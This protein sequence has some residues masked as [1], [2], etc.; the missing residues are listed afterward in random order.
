[1][2]VQS[3]ANWFI[4]DATLMAGCAM[5]IFHIFIVSI[6][7]GITE[8]LPISSSAHLILLPHIAGV[9]DQGMM[10]DVSVHLGTLIAVIVFFWADAKL[11]LLGL[12]GLLRG[13][14]EGRQSHLAIALVI[15]TIPA[16]VVGLVLKLTGVSDAMRDSVGL[17]GA[18]MLGFGIVLWWI[19]TRAPMVRDASEWTLRQAFVL[20]LW[21]AI[22]LIPGTSRSGITITGARQMGFT[23][24]SAARIS[25]LMSIPTI[26]AA[27]ALEAVDVL[28]YATAAAWREAAIATG[29]AGISAFF[30]L[31]L[32]MRL[33]RSVNFTPYVIY[34][35]VL[36]AGLMIWAYI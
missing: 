18:T 24:D 25:M 10:I 34:R 31:G 22:A 21:Q 14:I 33:L 26:M 3:F 27:G 4:G 17:I 15:A 32:M 35:I 6:I 12:I 29:F 19:D 8:F 36:G 23:R 7:Q 11:A 28:P 16:I 20:G 9:Q 2:R 5:S 30:A 13:K 1:M